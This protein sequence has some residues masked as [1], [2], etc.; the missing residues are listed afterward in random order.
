MFISSS[1]TPSYIKIHVQSLFADSVT[2]E[3]KITIAPGTKHVCV[4]VCVCTITLNERLAKSSESSHE[5][6]KISFVR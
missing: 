5:S 1:T 3:E 4:C 6:I 2:R